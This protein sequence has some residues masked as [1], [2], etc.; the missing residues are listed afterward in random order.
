MKKIQLPTDKA[1]RILAPRIAYIVTTVDKLGRVNAGSFSN[2]TS[3]ST[4]PER[5]VLAVYKAWDTIRN[6][7]A[8]REFVVNVPSKNLLREVW[9]CGDKYA[10]NPIPPGID[11]LK[12]AGLTEISSKKVRPPR[13]AEC[14]MHLECKVVWIK[15]VGD[16]YLI[17]GDI[18]S[19]SY[20]HGVFDQDFIQIISKTLPLMEISRDFF[21][22]PGKVVTVG[23]KEVRKIVNQ[24]LEKMNIK[25]S[26][27]LKI[28]KM[29][30][31]SEE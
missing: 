6:I 14:P 7:R 8:T 26:K 12:I 31:W 28:Y 30:R 4:D 11:E 21:T 3:V 2:L 19:A 25:V 16:H 10:G 1:H 17:L 22:S 29:L 24:E 23:R 5:L 27:K 13:V 15:N 18:V 20:T 9:I